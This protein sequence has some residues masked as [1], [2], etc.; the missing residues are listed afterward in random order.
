MSL[1]KELFKKK[2]QQFKAEGEMMNVDEQ[3]EKNK[4]NEHQDF[5]PETSLPLASGKRKWTEFFDE[6]KDVEISQG[7]V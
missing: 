5:P 4:K 7:N 3:S 2:L 1:T 6:K